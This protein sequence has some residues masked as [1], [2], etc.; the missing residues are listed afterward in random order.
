MLEGDL[1]LHKTSS[2]RLKASLALLALLVGMLGLAPHL[3]F[4]WEVGELTYFKSAY[5]EDTYV[6]LGGPE[7]APPYRLLSTILFSS[8]CFFLDNDVEWVLIAADFLFPFLCTLAAGY[9]AAALSRRIWWAVLL[10]MLILFG[11][12]L[13]SLGWVLRYLQHSNVWLPSLLIPDYFT[14]Y[15][16][17]FR[18]PEPQVSQIVLFTA[19]GFL[20]RRLPAY[21]QRRDRS[22]FWG[23]FGFHLL[24]IFC[25]LPV[26]LAIYVL[27]ALATVFL[28]QGP[29]KPAARLLALSLLFS[30]LSAAGV[31]T[32]FL[33]TGSASERIATLSFASHLPVLSPAVFYG[34][35][36]LGV[37]LVTRRKF[38][39]QGLLSVS[40]AFLMPQEM[41]QRKTRQ[42][43]FL[44]S[45]TP[46]RRG[47]LPTR[48][49]PALRCTQ[50][51][52]GGPKR[53]LSPSRTSNRCRRRQWTGSRTLLEKHP[54]GLS[55]QDSR[56]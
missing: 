25:Y 42:G 32:W 27:S 19:L 30:C 49:G 21:C 37:V 38:P 36:L 1:D 14:S 5:D 41:P 13:F 35:L 6:L 40:Q 7:V 11:Q 28:W 29:F 54:D 10:S 56:I 2:L 44:R 34:A 33:L 18:S 51:R 45:G 22:T 12:E 39:T 3:V 15:F 26:S 53:F 31:W 24:F 23:I 48:S 20:A 46:D 8:L 50:S 55:R 43:R 4:S 9:L 52:P 16:S 17:L 47:W